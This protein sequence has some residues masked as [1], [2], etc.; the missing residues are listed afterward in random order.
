MGFLEVMGALFC[1]LVFFLVIAIYGMRIEETYKERRY[2]QGVERAKAT[3]KWLFVIF[4]PVIWPIAL[5][6]WLGNGVW[7]GIKA[8]ANIGKELQIG[9]KL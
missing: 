7:N 1:V 2:G 6:V 4:F 8:M 5:V 9:K 3:R